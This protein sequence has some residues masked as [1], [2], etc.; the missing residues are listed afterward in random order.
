MTTTELLAINGITD[1]RSMQVGQKLKVNPGSSSASTS[2]P[3]AQPAPSITPTA[4]TTVVQSPADSSG[5]KTVEIRVVEADPLVESELEE[6]DS[7]SVF[8]NVE[9]I[10]VVPLDEL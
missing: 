10:P 3:E 2:K 1:P 9:E 4:P 6:I 7:D 5:S 8:E